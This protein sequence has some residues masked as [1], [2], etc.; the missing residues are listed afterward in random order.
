[1][2]ETGAASVVDISLFGKEDGDMEWFKEFKVIFSMTAVLIASVV[3]V[4]YLAVNG[5]VILATV[6]FAALFSAFVV[7]FG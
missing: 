1:M 5:M 2:A 4:F 3:A 6:L 7:T